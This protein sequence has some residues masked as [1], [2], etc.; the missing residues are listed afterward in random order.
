MS[1]HFIDFQNLAQERATIVFECSP[2]I[3]CRIRVSRL[4]QLL[5]RVVLIAGVAW[6]TL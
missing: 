6:L 4:E 3:Y 5:A 1:T 2:M